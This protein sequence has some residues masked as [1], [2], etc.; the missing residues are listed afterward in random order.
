SGCERKTINR[1]L[2][3]LVVGRSPDRSTTAQSGCERK[4]INRELN[5]FLIYGFISRPIKRMLPVRWSRIRN[6]NGVSARKVAGGGNDVAPTPTP[7]A[8]AASV[9]SSLTFT[10]AL[11]TT[12]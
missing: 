10:K 5:P 8:A 4:T 6:T 7:V 1:E 11:C 3:P 12:A 9:P 2:N